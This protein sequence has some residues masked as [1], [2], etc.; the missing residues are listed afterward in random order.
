MTD[1]GPMPDPRQLA[2]FDLGPVKAD[3]APIRVDPAAPAPPVTTAA[4]VSAARAI[5][6]LTLSLPVV[7]ATD[8]DPPGYDGWR[9][10][11]GVP[12]PRIVGGTCTELANRR[13][14]DGSLG[15][16]GWTACPHHLSVD[17]GEVVDL[18]PV[19]EAELVATTAGLPV[20]MGRRPSLSAIP[21]TAGEVH[22]FADCVAGRLDGRG[23]P[24]PYSCTLDVVAAYPDGAPIAVIAGALGVSEEVVRLVLFR[25]GRILY[26]PGEGA[27]DELAA[28][29]EP[30]R[31]KVSPA[32]PSKIAPPVPVPAAIVRVERDAPAVREL[33]AEELFTF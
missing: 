15:P 30:S 1:G 8:P 16:C 5:R 10:Y 17:V 19:R 18:G 4:H 13:R 31:A 33:T 20:E 27:W 32:V 12:R 23:S 6:A 21:E 14:P 28:G 3:P 22:E 24:L 9:D 2:M 26:R 7:A 11:L 29:A 25:T